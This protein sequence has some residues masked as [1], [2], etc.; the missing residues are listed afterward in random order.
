MGLDGLNLLSWWYCLYIVSCFGLTQFSIPWLQ[1][2]CLT[3]TLAKYCVIL[4][5]DFWY[6]RLVLVDW[7]LFLVALF[8]NLSVLLLQR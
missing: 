1:E 8:V 6:L 5:V 3:S 7:T 4:D 2:G